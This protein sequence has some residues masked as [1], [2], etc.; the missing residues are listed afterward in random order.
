MPTYSTKSSSSSGVP[1][2]H[3]IDSPPKK[4]SHQPWFAPTF[5]KVHVTQLLVNTLVHLYQYVEH[6]VMAD[7]VFSLASLYEYSS[8]NVEHHPLMKKQ[9]HQLQ[10]LVLHHLQSH[11]KY[12]IQLLLGQL[13]FPF[14]IKVFF[15]LL[16]HQARCN[17]SPLLSHS[18]FRLV[19]VHVSLI[20]YYISASKYLVMH[21]IPQMITLL[22]ST[23][24]NEH[25]FS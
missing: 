11:M 25:I 9:N 21:V 15:H 12:L 13:L 20:E 3:K 10:L 7:K 16:V 22:I 6:I 2:I 19:F 5:D 1:P 18:F 23:I 4:L 8:S 24:Y 14:Q 17:L